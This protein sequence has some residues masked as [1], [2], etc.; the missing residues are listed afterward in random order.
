MLYKKTEVIKDTL[1]SCKGDIFPESSNE[2]NFNEELKFINYGK[3]S[4]MKTLGLY[5]IEG[6]LPIT[7][8]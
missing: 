5:L 7:T 8:H 1:P 2:R 3:Q 4:V 6:P